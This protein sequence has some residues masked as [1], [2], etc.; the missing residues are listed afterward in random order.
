ME[1]YSSLCQRSHQLNN[2]KQPDVDMIEP[3][4]H[5]QE[6]QSE[7]FNQEQTE[8]LVDKIKSLQSQLEDLKT[9]NIE[10]TKQLERQLP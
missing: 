6:G 1:Q 10:M 4:P 8:N 2:E 7:V 5:A 9:K 3:E